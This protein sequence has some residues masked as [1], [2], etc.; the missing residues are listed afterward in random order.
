MGP[1]KVEVIADFYFHV[2]GMRGAASLR[3]YLFEKQV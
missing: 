1:C 3:G 2:T